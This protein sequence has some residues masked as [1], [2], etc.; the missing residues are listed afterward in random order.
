MSGCPPT[1]AP[2]PT[3][4]LARDVQRVVDADGRAAAMLGEHPGIGVVEDRDREV[5]VQG[6]REPGAERDVHPAEVRG[7]E[8]EAVGPPDDPGDRHA[9]ARRSGPSGNAAGPPARRTSRATTSSTDTS[10]SGPSTR[11]R[12]SVRP[13]SPTTAAAIDPTRTSNAEHHRAGRLRPDRAARA[14]PASR[15]GPRRPRTRSPRRPA[16]APGRGWRCGS[17]RWRR[18]APSASAG[19]LVEDPEDGA[20]GSPDGSSRCAGPCGRY[21]SATIL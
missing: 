16:R 5:E 17:G 7:H 21:R 19:R 20:R 1:I 18:R 2:P 6:T 10:S 3:P 4:D 12:S 13:P 11:M 14:G 8:H 9:D 15:G